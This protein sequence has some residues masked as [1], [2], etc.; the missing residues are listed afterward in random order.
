MWGGFL[1]FPCACQRCHALDR[2]LPGHTVSVNF[3]NPE[4]SYLPAY[5]M[6]MPG[7][8]LGPGVSNVTVI[9]VPAWHDDGRAGLD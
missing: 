9:E 4:D 3:S 2:R 8:I 5:R 1:K 7:Y 6:S